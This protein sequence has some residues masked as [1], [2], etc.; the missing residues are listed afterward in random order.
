MVSVDKIV[1][2]ESGKLDNAGILDLFSELIRDGLAW[3][4]QGCYGRMAEYLI[5]AG[6]LGRDG[7]ILKIES[8][9]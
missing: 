4:L 3:S 9:D 1:A 2:Y 5:E 8:E 7:T 6:Y